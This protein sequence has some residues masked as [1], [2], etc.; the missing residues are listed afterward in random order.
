MKNQY[1]YIISYFPTEIYSNT[2]VL[3][4]LRKKVLGRTI[5]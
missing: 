2:K 5:L 3:C 4:H 1:N